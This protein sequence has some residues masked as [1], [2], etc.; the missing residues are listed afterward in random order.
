MKIFVNIWRPLRESFLGPT[1]VKRLESLGEVRFCEDLPLC[2]QALREAAQGADLLLTG[3]GQKTVHAADIP[4]VKL[5]A[6]TGGTVGGIIDTDVFERGTTVLSGNTHYAESVAEGVIAYMLFALRQMG[7]YSAELSKGNWQPNFTEGLLDQRV[8]IIS[9]GAVSRKVLEHLQMYRAKVKVYSS[10]PDP[11]Y[12]EK[13]GF[14]YAS[15]EEIFSSCRVV[16]VHTARTPDTVHMIRK[17]HFA[18]LE[19]GA[20]FLNTARGEVIDEAALTAELKT[21]RI[22]AV[23]DVF[24]SEPLPADSPFLGLDNVILFPHL[25][26]PTYDRRDY[27]TNALLDD[28]VSFFA[29]GAVQN[30]VT[31]DVAKRMTH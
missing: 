29:G 19:D 15:L 27:I 13:M 24:Q 25:C 16:S 12:A 2:G 3:W 18:M 26:G 28:A 4:T 11:A 21:G 7:Y 9:V 6:H 23:L 10:R 8:G 5:V 22:R 20:V 14:T 31:L 30:E 1:T 17:E